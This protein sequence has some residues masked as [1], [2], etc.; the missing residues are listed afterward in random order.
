VSAELMPKEVWQIICVIINVWGNRSLLTHICQLTEFGNI[1]KNCL[2]NWP[3]GGSI[4]E[5][6]RQQ[7][8]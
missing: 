6:K 4:L 5:V 7:G 8:W 2:V 1:A 3:N